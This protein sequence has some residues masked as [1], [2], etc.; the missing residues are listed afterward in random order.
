MTLIRELTA[1]EAALG[2]RELIE[3]CYDQGWT[4]GLPVVPPVQEFVD[5]FLAQTARDPDEVLMVQE[6]LDRT[7]TVRHAAIN[8][9]MAGCRPEYFP[10]LLAALDAFESGVA[11]TNLMQSTTGQAVML[12]VNG[13]IRTEL[14]FNSTGNVFGPGDRP[15]TTLGRAVRLII[16]NVLGI[17]PHEFDQSTQGTSAK[18]ACCIA[19]NEEE[20]PWEPFHVEFGFAPDVS[21]V[22]TQMMRSDIF[23]EHRRSQVPEEILATIADSMSYAG[24]ITQ[25]TDQLSKHSTIVVM[26]PEHA[27]L[28]ARQGWSKQDVKRYLWEHCGKTKAELLRYGKLH[29]DYEHEPE[30]AFIRH[31]AGPE[32]IWLLVAGANNGGVS[33]VCPAITLGR[34]HDVTRRIERPPG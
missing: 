26:G 29:P 12:I 4:D 20:S 31:S 9:V 13:P 21:T 3:H 28:I 17:R 34:G 19:E 8:A 18:Y 11:R 6:H 1:H 27:Q 23:V 33:S 32:D 24:M 14:G 15:N 2:A 22:T 5:E 25:V 10:V 7:C 16:M 30:D